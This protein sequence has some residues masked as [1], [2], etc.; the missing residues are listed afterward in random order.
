MKR[1]KSFL[2]IG[3]ALLIG[4]MF[5]GSALSQSLSG[6]IW[7]LQNP[8]I[9][10]ESELFGFNQ[11]DE[12]IYMLTSLVTGETHKVMGTYSL[13]GNKL[14]IRLSDRTDYFDV[15]L[16]NAN[17]IDLIKDSS[18]LHLAKAGSA[19]DHLLSDYLKSKSGGDSY[20]NN[21]STKHTDQMCWCCYGT[22]K[23]NVC[24]GK[25]TMDYPSRTCRY[26]GGSGIC[27]HCN[28]TGKFIS[29]Y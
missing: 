19:A 29:K 24:K 28:G 12:F 22:G 20:D 9:S 21:Y 1:K 25:G 15:A 4:I 6:H 16:K 17:E 5:Y 18:I 11:D 2:G 8:E 7:R 27:K 23:C 13:I 26:C 14:A 10:S 3:L